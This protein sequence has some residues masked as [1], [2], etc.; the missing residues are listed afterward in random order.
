MEK[1]IISILLVLCSNIYADDAYQHNFIT[2][3]NLSSAT[4][5]IWVTGEPYKIEENSSLLVPCY[6]EEI[7]YVQTTLETDTLTCGKQKEL[8][9]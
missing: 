8:N 6:P 2:V 3:K 1:I 9:Q 5:N 4:K 7:L